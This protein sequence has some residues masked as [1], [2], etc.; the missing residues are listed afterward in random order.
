MYN[1]TI[2]ILSYVTNRETIEKLSIFII[3]LSIYLSLFIIY[4]LI[5]RS[6]YLSR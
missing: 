3:Y 4:L 6:G 2:E 1:K 5:N